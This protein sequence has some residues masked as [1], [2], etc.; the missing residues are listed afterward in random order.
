VLTAWRGNFADGIIPPYT[1]HLWSLAIEEQFYLLWPWAVFLFS[2]RG[3]LKLCLATVVGAWLVRFAALY[4]FDNRVAGY[5][6]M[7]ARMDALA[8]GALVCL[9]WRNEHGRELLRRWWRP[10]TWASVAVLVVCIAA[11]ARRDVLLSTFDRTAQL[12]AFPAIALLC[13]AVLGMYVIHIPLARVVKYEIHD[14]G[15]LPRWLGSSLPAQLLLTTCG[16]LACFAIS[17]ISYNVYEKR[18]LALRER[19]TPATAR[20]G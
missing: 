15:G 8:A 2:P 20:S 11:N 6:L 3:F 17:W 13:A 18:F 19:F 7:P 12:A 14:A 1:T 9:A 10:A 5:V 4:V 16:V